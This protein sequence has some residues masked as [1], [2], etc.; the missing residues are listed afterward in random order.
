MYYTIFRG[1]KPRNLMCATPPAPTI[2]VARAMS[3]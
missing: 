3:D 2:F 1:F